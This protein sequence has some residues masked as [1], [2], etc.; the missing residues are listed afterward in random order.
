VLSL[1]YKIQAETNARPVGKMP[2]I[3][4]WRAL[5]I[6]MV[7]FAHST[8]KPGFSAWCAAVHFPLLTSILSDG[9][10]GVRFFFV[11]SGFLIT[12]LLILEQA[13]NNCVSLKKFYIRRGLR[14]L[15]V[16]F[17]FLA[18]VAVLQLTTNLHQAPIT[19]G[20]GSDFH[21]QLFNQRRYFGSSL[22]ALR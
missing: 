13:Q 19:W 18:V 4:G 11:I 10:L 8:D 20:G 17:A 15:P 5:S 14:I 21:G 16:Y 2:S 1:K 3:D 6:L 7:L 9:Y 22:V 12:Y